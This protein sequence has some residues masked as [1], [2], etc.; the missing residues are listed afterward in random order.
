MEDI[1]E[2]WEKGIAM[3]YHN[4]NKISKDNTTETVLTRIHDR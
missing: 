3:E 1:F 2:V 4:K